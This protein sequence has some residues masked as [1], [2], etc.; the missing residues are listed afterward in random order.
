MTSSTCERSPALHPLKRWVGPLV[1]L[2][3]GVSPGPSA[4]HALSLLRCI[5]S[6]SGTELPTSALQRFRPQ[7]GALLTFGGRDREDWDSAVFGQPIWYRHVPIGD[8]GQ[9]FQRLLPGAGVPFVFLVFW[10]VNWRGSRR[11]LRFLVYSALTLRVEEDDLACRIT[12]I[13]EFLFRRMTA[14]WWQT[15]AIY[16]VYPRSFQDTNGDGVGNLAGIERRL[17]Y[18][19]GLGIDAI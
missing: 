13:A 5:E 4:L 17:D 2:A 15:G 16:Q 3:P 10:P 14:R 11:P 9:S 8:G 19:A 1:S 18:L 7:S 6:G 12:P